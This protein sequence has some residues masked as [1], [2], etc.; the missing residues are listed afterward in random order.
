MY[1]VYTIDDVRRALQIPDFDAQAAQAKMMP[2]VRPRQRPDNLNGQARLGGVLAL[3]YCAN[4]TLTVV[5]TRRR[6][7]LNSHAGQISFPGGRKEAAETLLTTALRETEEEIGI[8]PTQVEVL[9]PLASLYI[10]PSDYEVH[11]FV[12]WSLAGKRP[13]FS[14]SKDEVAEI[15]E[16]PL[17][18]LM[19]PATRIE[20]P[21]DFRGHEVIIPY[22]AVGEHKVWG[23]TAMMLSELFERLRAVSAHI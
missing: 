15:L 6:D 20:A 2:G 5:L 3:L 14:A 17:R 9:G 23:A 4:D 10:P 22:Y 7:D 13:S 8:L 21:W 12:A 11:P 18:K 19:H 1:I 16:V